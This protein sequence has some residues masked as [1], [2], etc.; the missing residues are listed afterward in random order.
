VESPDGRFLYYAKDGSSP[1]S[2]WRLPVGGG[3][4]TEIAD[5]LSHARNFVVGQRGLYFVAVGDAPDKT[6]VDFYE[7]A[8]G[9]RTTLLSLGKQ[10]WYG[11]ALAP[12]ERSILVSTVD[13]A[14]SNLMV[15]DRIQ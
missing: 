1:T 15:V 8:T 3:E 14:G 10:W 12:D 11:M 6:S 9:K 7:F 5:G 2:I 13:S 4:E